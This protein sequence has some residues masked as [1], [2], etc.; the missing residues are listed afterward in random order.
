MPDVHLSVKALRTLRKRLSCSVCFATI[1]TRQ[2]PFLVQIPRSTLPTSAI[3]SHLNSSRVMC[4]PIPHQVQAQVTRYIPPDEDFDEHLRDMAGYVP[5]QARGSAWR[6]HARAMSPETTCLAKASVTPSAHDGFTS[7]M[8]VM[9]RLLPGSVRPTRGAPARSPPA[10]H[11]SSAP[12]GLTTTP[13]PTDNRPRKHSPNTPSPIG[14]SATVFKPRVPLPAHADPMLDTP[15]IEFLGEVY[16]AQLAT[17][18][19]NAASRR[20]LEQDLKWSSIPRPAGFNREAASQQ[21]VEAA[22]LERREKGLGRRRRGWEGVEAG[23]QAGAQMQRTVQADGRACV[24]CHGQGQG[25]G[26]Q[27]TVVKRARNMAGPW[28]QQQDGPVHELE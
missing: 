11:V 21:Q 22:L 15:D 16:C 26:A 24:H 20:A 25:Q 10:N 19:M 5:G 1:S 2:W 28:R 8:T 3:F 17:Q 13:S 4:H 14:A 18:G 6:M 27:A 23:I 7:G 12:P 9:P